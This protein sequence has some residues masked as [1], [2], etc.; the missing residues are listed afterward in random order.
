MGARKSISNSFTVNT[1]EDGATL[2][3]KSAIHSVGI[4]CTSDGKSDGSG[5]SAGMVTLYVDGVA[6]PT[7]YLSI[8]SQPSGLTVLTHTQQSAIPEG[9]VSISWANNVDMANLEGEVVLTVSY[10]SYSTE[11]SI[12]IICAKDGEDGVTYTIKT[13]ITGVTIPSNHYGATIPSLQANFYKN[14]ATEQTSFTCYYGLYFRS[15]SGGY[16]LIASGQDSAYAVSNLDIDYGSYK[17]SAIAIFMFK[18]SYS[19]TSPQTQPCYASI[20]IPVVKNGD[21]GPTGQRGKIGRFFYYAG[22]WDATNNTDA[23][24]VNDGNAPFFSKAGS[25]AN[26]YY[27]YNP[28]TNPS[29]GSLTMKQMAD[30]SEKVDGQ[31]AWNKAPWEVMYNDFK[32]IITKALFTDFAMLGGFVVSGD[33]LISQYGVVRKFFQNSSRDPIT[34]SDGTWYFYKQ[35]GSSAYIYTLEITS[36]GKMVTSPSGESAAAYTYFD[37]FDETEYDA[38]Y[39]QFFPTYCVNMATGQSKMGNVEVEGQIKCK[40]LKTGIERVV[41]SPSGSTTSLAASEY[42]DESAGNCP[43]TVMFMLK[44]DYRSAAITIGLPSASIFN[45]CKIDFIMPVQNENYLALQFQGVRVAVNNSSAIDNYMNSK[46]VTVQCN[47][48]ASGRSLKLGKFTVVSDGDYWWLIDA[49]NVTTS[50]GNIFS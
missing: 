38:D 32:Y 10:N 35:I 21:T 31:I 9:G 14:T 20:E 11:F 43:T 49:Q 36:K 3:A 30:A 28:A 37:G 42:S 2:T 1:V 29:G 16:S 17:I 25:S 46:Q 40:S 45:G 4:R 22:D 48:G 18:S 6:V 5:S 50:G 26:A 12:P 19:S 15:E 44:N 47:Y 33:F 41:M 34:D 7:T 23:F 8:K 24:V 13:N 39:I 27:V